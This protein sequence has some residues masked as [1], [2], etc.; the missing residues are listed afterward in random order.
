VLKVGPKADIGNVNFTILN[1]LFQ[2]PLAY[3][4]KNVGRYFSVIYICLHVLQRFAS[5]SMIS[6]VQDSAFF[7]GKIFKNTPLF[8]IGVVHA[9]TNIKDIYWS[10]LCDHCVFKTALVENIFKNLPHHVH[11]TLQLQQNVFFPRMLP[12]ISPPFGTANLS[13]SFKCVVCNY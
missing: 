13:L 12:H 2:W 1:E 3:W 11:S 6:T 5:S 9:T 8:I 10:V 4:A 7:S